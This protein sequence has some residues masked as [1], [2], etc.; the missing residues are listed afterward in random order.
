M[1][2]VDADGR[3]TDGGDAGRISTKLSGINPIRSPNRT[4][5]CGVH[6]SMQLAITFG[7]IL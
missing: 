3:L 6:D 1:V 2:L 5:M 4:C 7:K